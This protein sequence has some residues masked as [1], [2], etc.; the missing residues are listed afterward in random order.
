MKY[1]TL[2]AAAATTTSLVTAAGAYR[3]GGSETAWTPATQT[4]PPVAGFTLRPTPALRIPRAGLLIREDD[5]DDDD[6]DEDGRGRITHGSVTAT[7][8]PTASGSGSVTSAPRPSNTCGWDRNGGCC[9]GNNCRKIPKQC[10]E[11]NKECDS[12]DNGGT[13][14]CRQSSAPACYTWLIST[15]TAGRQETYSMLGCTDKPGTGTLLPTDPASAGSSSTSSSG[16][17]GGGGGGGKSNTGAIVGGVIG[18]ILALLLVLFF[19]WYVLRQRRRGKAE[20]VVADR[21]LR[22]STMSHASWAEEHDSRSGGGG[23]EKSYEA[24]P[25]RKPVPGSETQDSG[26]TATMSPATTTTTTTDRGSPN[27]HLAY[28]VS[29]ASGT[30]GSQGG[31][32]VVSSLSTAAP[33]PLAGVVEAPDTGVPQDSA[34]APVEVAGTT[35]T[36]ET[37]QNRAEL[38]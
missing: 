6:D 28:S 14:C 13:L 34:A 29:S 10:V 16:G 37:M 9:S 4:Q 24:V 19:I 38:P 31:T 30:M 5:D 7:S 2:A 11:R 18:G 20:H 25:R 36:R 32:G 3:H 27:E 33:P 17:G 22:D 12:D 23:V 21:S 15:S 1:T 8:T 26:Y 35:V